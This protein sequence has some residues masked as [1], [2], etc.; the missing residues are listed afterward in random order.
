[1]E[2]NDITSALIGVLDLRLF[3]IGGTVFTVASF[4]AV[5]LVVVGTIVTSRLLQRVVRM[6]LTRVGLSSEG[7]TGALGSLVNYATLLVGSFVAL[8]TVGIQLTSAASPR[9]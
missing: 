2:P 6:L 5:L 4:V 9:C 1:M 7:T 3:E 8:Q